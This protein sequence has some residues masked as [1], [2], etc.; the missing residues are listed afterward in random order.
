MVCNPSEIIPKTWPLSVPAQFHAIPLFCQ[1]LSQM[2]IQ[3]G[4]R[5]Y[6]RKFRQQSLYI[7]AANSY[8]MLVQIPGD[9]SGLLCDLKD[10]LLFHPV[11]LSF[12]YL[13]AFK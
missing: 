6:S 9:V 5:P 2:G 7:L 12:Q 1:L 4:T 3:A 11:H 8:N 13:F 10:A